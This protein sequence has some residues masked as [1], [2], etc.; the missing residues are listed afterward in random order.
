MHGK[1]ISAKERSKLINGVIKKLENMF[2]DFSN[3]FNFVFISYHRQN[4]NK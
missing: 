4:N 2:V 3:S 1:K